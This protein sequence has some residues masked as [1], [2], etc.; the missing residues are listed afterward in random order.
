M[1]LLSYSLMVISTTVGCWV[2]LV[3]VLVVHR[4]SRCCCCYSWA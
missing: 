2:V 3:L 1:T 4:N